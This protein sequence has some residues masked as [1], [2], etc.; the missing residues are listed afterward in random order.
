M[1]Q[2]PGPCHFQCRSW[3]SSIHISW[4]TVCKAEFPTSL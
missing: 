2:T 3:I 4:E 1:Q